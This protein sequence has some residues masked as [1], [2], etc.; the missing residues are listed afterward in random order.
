MSD[1]MPYHSTR[2]S[3]FSLKMAEQYLEGFKKKFIIANKI[4]RP[5][6]VHSH[7]LWLVTALSRVFFQNLPILAT[8]HNTALRQIYLAPHLKEYIVNPIRLLDAIAVI[9]ENQ[10]NRIKNLYQFNESLE[11]SSQFYFVGQAINTEIF[12]PQEADENKIKKKQ[13]RPVKNKKRIVYAG[14]L[15]NS[16]GVPQLIEAFKEV[17]EMTNHDYELL[18]IGSG[19]GEEKEKIIKMASTLKNRIKALGQID[20]EQLASIF[21][22]S[23][24]FI[25]PSFYDGFPKVLLE[26][27]ACGCKAIMTDIP[28]I[29]ETLVN[30]CGPSKNIKFISLPKMKTIDQPIQSE[31]P[32]F[33]NRIKTAIL[34]YINDVSY[35]TIDYSYADKVRKEFGWFGLFKRYLEIYKR[36]IIIQEF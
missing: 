34:S 30:K 29:Q 18:L 1:Q 31:I 14:K 24:L 10:K 15:S 13:K 5:N 35:D 26:S 4:F 17:C 27:L 9:N 7:H 21:R 22:S 25:L 11:K 3:D 12:Y 33:I 2:F 19:K 23:E 20:Q 16:K 8:C 36:L 6:V 28:G 32:E